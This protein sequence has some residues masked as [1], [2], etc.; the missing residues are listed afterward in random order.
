MAQI[1]FPTREAPAVSKG[2][3]GGGK[4]GQLLGAVAGGAAAAAAV[5]TGGMSLAAVPA[6]VGAAA[7]GGSLGGIIGESVR[8]GR[9]A[10]AGQGSQPT[11]GI[12]A[13]TGAVDRRLNEIEKNPHFQL[14]QAQAALP[15][16]SPDIQKQF[17]PTIE[18]ALAASRKAQQVGAV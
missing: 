8:P 10:S 3:A 11:Q 14:K 16:L 4:M 15:Q 12:Q 18:A 5:P 6:I 9:Q 1:R 13:N 17:A 7:G 2:R